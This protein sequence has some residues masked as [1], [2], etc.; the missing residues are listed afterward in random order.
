MQSFSVVCAAA[1]VEDV[2]EEGRNS[3]KFVERSIDGSAY[4]GSAY[5][6]VC[7]GTD[8]ERRESLVSIQTDHGGP[9]GYAI[10]MWV[11]HEKEQVLRICKTNRCNDV[12]TER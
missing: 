7:S 12:H 8:G 1:E 3:L 2:P 4:H 11:K 5:E 10:A 6:F 9:G